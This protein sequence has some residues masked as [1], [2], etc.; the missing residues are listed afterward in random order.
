MK[1]LY[2]VLSAATTFLV[3]VLLS[4]CILRVGDAHHVYYHGDNADKG[5]PPVDGTLYYSGDPITVLPKGDLEKTG[6]TFQGWR[7]K[8]TETPYQAGNTLFMGEA[9]IDFTAVWEFLGEQYRYDTKA[10]EVTITGYVGVEREQVN[11][12]SELGKNPVKHIGDEAFSNLRIYAV[13]LP[14][15]LVSIGAKAF[16]NNYLSTL[17]IPDSVIAIGSIAFSYNALEKLTFGSGPLSIG[18]YAF[19]G[20]KLTEV[21]IPALTEIGTGAFSGNRITVITIGDGVII[22][23]DS[24]LGDYGKTFRAYYDGKGKLAGSYCYINDGWRQIADE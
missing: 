5:S 10:G 23:S 14:D 22:E 7:Q 13:K 2:R 20:N 8:Y 6:Y 12:P 24:S 18:D 1:Q 17:T 16:Y 3:V 11:V 4:G 21:S 9:D 19:D 15:G